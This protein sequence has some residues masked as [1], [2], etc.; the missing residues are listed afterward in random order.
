MRQL[1]QDGQDE[2]PARAAA[3]P[4]R[5]ALARAA[6]GDAGARRDLTVAL[7]RA[8]GFYA[9]NP[10]R[11]AALSDLCGALRV[12]VMPPRPGA[13]RQRLQWKLWLS[14]GAAATLD[15]QW[16]QR[17]EQALRRYGRGLETV[18]VVPVDAPRRRPPRRRRRP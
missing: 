3:P 13:P 18:R 15:A 11:H 14:G 5:H 8:V 17:L 2:G 6:A 9:A 16:P 1:G 4:P 10:D 12:A 7:L